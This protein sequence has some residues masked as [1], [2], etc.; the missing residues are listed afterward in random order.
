MTI[1]SDSFPRLAEFRARHGVKIGYILHPSNPK[2]PT[3]EQWHFPL[4]RKVAYVFMY[5]RDG[6]PSAW[7]VAGELSFGTA[8]AVSPNPDDAAATVSHGHAHARIA[9]LEALAIWAGLE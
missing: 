7:A 8:A 2:A 6:V 9:A 1:S 3:V 4:F 5:E